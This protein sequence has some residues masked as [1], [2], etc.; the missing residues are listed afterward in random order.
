[1]KKDITKYSTDKKI[2]VI[3]ELLDHPWRKIIVKEID[4]VMSDIKWKFW[5]PCSDQSFRFNSHN[6]ITERITALHVIKNLPNM[7]LFDFEQ[8]MKSDKEN[9]KPLEQRL[10]EYDKK[11]FNDL[12]KFMK[13]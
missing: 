2:S 7:T 8:I 11:L 1:M 10:E 3:K 6:L 4:K 12:S 13:L 5:I 9:L